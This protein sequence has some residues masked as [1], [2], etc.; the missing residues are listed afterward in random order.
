M[1]AGFHLSKSYFIE[2]RQVGLPMVVNIVTVDRFHHALRVEHGLGP[3]STASFARAACL[4]TITVA[5]LCASEQGI[6]Y[7]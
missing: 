1:E 4:A 5:L 7:S 3:L 6:L 2:D